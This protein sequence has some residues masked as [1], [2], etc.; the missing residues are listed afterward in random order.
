MND[1]PLSPEIEAVRRKAAGSSFYSAM[2][3]LPKARR[4][5]MY[6]I[7]AFC[8]A[9]DDIADD[10]E[11]TREERL[12]ELDDWRDDL[13]ALYTGAHAGRAAFL[14]DVVE[15]YGPRLADFLTVIDGM[16][17][18]L[19]GDIVAPTLEALDLYCDRVASAVGRLSTKVFG[20][21]DEP[22]FALAFHLGRA[23]QLTNILRDLD[24]DAAAGRLYLPR[25][26]LG[27]IGPVD[28]QAVLAKPSIDEA[29]RKLAALARKHYE[30]SAAIMASRPKGDLR[31]PKLM[32]A[33]YAEILKR[34]EEQ[35]WAPPRARVKVPKVLLGWLA[36]RYGIAA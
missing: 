17:M 20:M 2:K 32:G 4:E 35:G 12:V 7:Y 29:C 15:T 25:D 22:G 36:L 3:L 1:V 6:A 19:E 8:R 30:E 33:V 28:P 5:G 21:D 24:E 26:F 11:G 10:G 13:R 18:D 23:L 9:V 14:N 27:T 16:A 34:M 31:A